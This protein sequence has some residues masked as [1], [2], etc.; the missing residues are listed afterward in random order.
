MFFFLSKILAFL[1]FPLTWIVILLVW[2]FL[3]KS[4]TRKKRLIIVTV[5]VTLFFSN[6]FVYDQLVMLY[7]PK[8]SLIEPG[9]KFSAGILLGGMVGYDKY[10]RGYFS[11]SGD[12]FIQSVKLYHEGIIQK[13]CI[14]GGSGNIF[15]PKLK[16]ADFITGELIASGVA[17]KDIISENNSRSTFENA[18]FTKKIF[19]SL[20]LTGPYVL[21]TSA[22]HMPRAEKVFR[23]AGI[24][25][26][27]FPCDYHVKPSAFSIPH[28][29]I[30]DLVLLYEWSYFIKE[31]IG[32]QVYTWTGKS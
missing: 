30:P 10:G 9:K 5:I 19:D 20:H 25:I 26:V 31:L 28:L 6:K 24:D 21:I 16:E 23:K 29:I 12:R 27:P 32:T 14:S 18:V 1:L 3:T 17:E 22:L 13:I 11:E 7:Q 15:Q 4:K 8:K 2:I